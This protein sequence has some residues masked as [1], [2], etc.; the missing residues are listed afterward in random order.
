MYSCNLESRVKYKIFWPL[1]ETVILIS[2]IFL[3]LI[4]FSRTGNMNSSLLQ[5][6]PWK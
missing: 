3:I 4:V 6:Q 5:W 2:Y 1:R